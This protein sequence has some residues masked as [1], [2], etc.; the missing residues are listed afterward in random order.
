M[1]PHAACNLLTYSI[2]KA[3]NTKAFFVFRFTIRATSYHM[4]S[5]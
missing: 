2:R 4:I 5:C 1:T 3:R